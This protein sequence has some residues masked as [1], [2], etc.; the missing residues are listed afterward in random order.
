ML[1]PVKAG[2]SRGAQ[3]LRL[4][5]SRPR[6]H[7]NRARPRSVAVTA[8]GRM[9]NPR[10][11]LSASDPPSVA[12]T[13]SASCCFAGPL[14]LCPG[15]WRARLYHDLQVD[16]PFQ[17]QGHYYTFPRQ[18]HHVLPL[19]VLPRRQVRSQGVIA[20]NASGASASTLHLKRE[21]SIGRSRAA[22]ARPLV[23]CCD[24]APAGRR[25]T[26]RYARLS[27]QSIVQKPGISAAHRIGKQVT[28]YQ[29]IGSIICINPIC[30]PPPAHLVKRTRG[31]RGPTAT[32]TG[33]GGIT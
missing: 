30:P 33:R 32:A 12:T 13:C 19:H 10:A 1:L 16:E 28:L 9:K 17:N 26:T 21:P 24:G 3:R 20:R 7:P 18:G 6:A 11:S 8:F 2:D 27:L 4:E 15:M 31:G 25:A 5:R 29:M 14:P 22:H 23:D